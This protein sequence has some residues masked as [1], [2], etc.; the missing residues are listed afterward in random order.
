MENISPGE[1]RTSTRAVAAR[2]PFG[3]PLGP[4]LVPVSQPPGP[5]VHP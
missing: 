3:P 4:P 2:S 5:P 1:E